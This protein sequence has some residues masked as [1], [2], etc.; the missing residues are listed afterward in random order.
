M[1]R[2]L[3]RGP[4]SGACRRLN[5]SGQGAYTTMLAVLPAVEHPLPACIQRRVGRGVGRPAWKNHEFS[6]RGSR[7]GKLIECSAWIQ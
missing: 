4:L 6:S 2:A 5:R 3:E 7:I 1:N